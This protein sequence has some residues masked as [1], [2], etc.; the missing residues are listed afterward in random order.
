MDQ[1]RTLVRPPDAG[2]P[3][4]GGHCLVFVAGEG[5]LGRSIAL[6]GELVLGR[7]AACAVPLAADDVSRR[8]AR[9]AP[10][11]GGHVL[12]DLDSTN[13]TF[14][15]GRRVGRH[16]LAPG[17]RVQVGPFVAR[18]LRAGD[19][20]AA[21]LA[22]LADLAQRDPLT[23]LANRRAF[24]EALRR[25]V[26]RAR[27][28]GAPL[29]VA[30]LDV[31]HFK[32]VNDAHGHAAGD[33]VLAAVAARAAAALRAG[34]LL[35]RVG[36][37]EF[38]ALLPGAGLAAARGGGGA[39]ARRHR[40][41]AGRGG[42]TPGRGDRLARLRRARA[43]RRGRRRPPRPRRRAA[44]PGQA[45]RARPGGLLTHAARGRG[46]DRPPARATRKRLRT[47]GR[48]VILAPA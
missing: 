32:R 26:A 46:G 43:G 17:D 10:E 15:N 38:A 29:A 47:R 24:E 30:A 42:R 6:D 13:G 33:A 48:R 19:A 12:V 20:E 22:A 41:R 8:H 14:V 4:A 11:G 40:G 39:R 2:E 27:R 37:E 25:E 31:D 34:D 3:P 18:Y 21:A 44:V 16:R 9:V 1:D 36:G 45:G 7:D 35:A 23:G 5:A 28:S